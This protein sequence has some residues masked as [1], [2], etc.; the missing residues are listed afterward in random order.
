MD[1]ELARYIAAL[2]R[3]GGSPWALPYRDVSL[4]SPVVCPAVRA[5]G[6]SLRALRARAALHRCARAHTAMHFLHGRPCD[7]CKPLCVA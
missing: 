4:P 3:R 5:A 1:A 7:E 2:A 6:V